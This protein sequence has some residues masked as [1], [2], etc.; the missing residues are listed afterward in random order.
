MSQIC[1]V[2]GKR[3]LTGCNVSHSHRR[4]KRR[5]QPNLHKHRVWLE[6]ENRF[7]TLRVSQKGLRTIDKKGL[8]SVLADIG[9]YQGE[10]QI[11]E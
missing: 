2:T 1:E 7:V 4:T 9:R 10:I 6:K 3:P 8:E 5:F 11:S